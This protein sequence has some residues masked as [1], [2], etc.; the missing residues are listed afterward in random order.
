MP[1]SFDNF[2]VLSWTTQQSS[3]H[4]HCQYAGNSRSRS[5]TLKLGCLGFSSFCGVFDAKKENALILSMGLGANGLQPSN[6]LHCLMPR[7]LSGNTVMI[8]CKMPRWWQGFGKDPS[9]I[10]PHTA[11]QI[12]TN[13]LTKIRQ[14]ERTAGINVMR[15]SQRGAEFTILFG[16]ETNQGILATTRRSLSHV[17]CMHVTVCTIYYIPC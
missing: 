9:T 3:H 1:S 2:S 16:F 13:V 8:V 7:P 4:H 14:I 17:S 12:S 6:I 15:S 11:W 5:A 10:F